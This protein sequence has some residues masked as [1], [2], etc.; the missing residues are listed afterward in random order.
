VRRQIKLLSVC[1]RA[2]WI[3]DETKICVAWSGAAQ[4][5]GMKPV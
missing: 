3:E 1:C 5:G 4:D 2:T